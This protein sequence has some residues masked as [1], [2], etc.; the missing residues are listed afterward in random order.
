MRGAPAEESLE[1]LRPYKIKLITRLDLLI[2]GSLL[3]R[4]TERSNPFIR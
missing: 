1:F 4:V 3:I 2:R